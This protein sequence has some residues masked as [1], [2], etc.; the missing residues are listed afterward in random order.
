MKLFFLLC[1]ITTQFLL[2][3]DLLSA[4]IV[5]KICEIKLKIVGTGTQRILY[6]AFGNIGGFPNEVYIGEEKINNIKF[7]INLTKKENIIKLRWNSRFLSCQKMFYGCS[8]I[9]EIDFSSFNNPDIND[10]SEMFSSCISLKSINF[11]NFYTSKVITMEKMFDFCYNL[12]SLNLSTFDTQKVQRMQCLFHYCKKLKFLNLSNFN[13]SQVESVSQIFF[14][15]NDLKSIDLSGFKNSKISSIN[16]MFYECYSLTSVDLSN[17]Y[18]SNQVSL[19]GTFY[20]CINLKEIDLSKL[21]DIGST[22]SAFYNC[23]SLINLNFPNFKLTSNINFEDM[24]YNCTILKY[25]NMSNAVENS[26]ASYVSIFQGIGDGLKFC[27]NETKTPKLYQELLKVNLT[28]LN[29]SYCLNYIFNENGVSKCTKFRECP[30]KYDKLIPA[31]KECIDDCSKDDK[32]RYEFR[33]KCYNNCSIDNFTL[34]YKG[35]L[36][37]I[38]CPKELPF[39]MVEYQECVSNCNI[40]V[41]LLKL[42]IIKYEEKETLNITDTFLDNILEELESN[43]L[44]INVLNNNS[45]ITFEIKGI[46]FII[47]KIKLD[48]NIYNRNRRIEII[49]DN[50]YDCLYRLRI[51]YDLPNEEYLYILNIQL[52]HL[53]IKKHIYR[54]YL[55]SNTEKILK[56]M[57]LSQC[58]NNKDIFEM[59]K[60]EK[61]SIESIMNNL[62]LSC[63]KNNGFYELYNETNKVFKSCFKNINGYYLDNDNQ[64]FK[65][66]YSTCSTCENE[67]NETNHNCNTCNNKNP[68]KS[69][70]NCYNYSV[71]CSINEKNK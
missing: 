35:Y 15:C 68:Y 28:S 63:N 56:R 65:S 39:E 11:S 1:L 26:A 64:V 53:G 33:K 36:C 41:M 13:V 62:C 4:K 48:N 24:F 49:D 22:Y 47:S 59:A 3:I 52:D 31:K 27:I 14:E 55:Y 21:S 29:C 32:Y 51:I 46:I 60:C 20:N 7:S 66:C 57:D 5:S 58:E 34:K 61:Y 44:D 23:H 70:S 42:C 2:E 71:D 67:G 43:N 12:I 40:N 25:I 18:S 38:E 16:Y 6:S 8:N 45:N 54:V 10:T 17:F 37:D 69:G 19:H 9:T 50:L 30:E